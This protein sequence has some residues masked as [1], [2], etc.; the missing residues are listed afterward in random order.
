MKLRS[1]FRWMTTAASAAAILALPASF[2]LAGYGA[3]GPGD[4]S[5]AALPQAIDRAAGAFP[6]RGVALV[7][8]GAASPDDGLPPYEGDQGSAGPSNEGSGYYDPEYYGADFYAAPASGEL[9]GSGWYGPGWWY[10]PNGWFYA[11]VW[12]YAPP[13]W[14][15][16]GF[17]WIGPGPFFGHRHF[18]HEHGRFV[19]RGRFGGHE[20]FDRHGGFGGRERF[21]G[22]GGFGDRGRSGMRGGDGGFRGGFG[23]GRAGGGRR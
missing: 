22:R 5:P 15:S 6:A 3:P 13:L 12:W 23:G 2:A 1:F 16:P 17:V 20:R 7:S 9:Y 21:Q 10:G 14:F 18:F 4:A 19:H 8:D 11:N